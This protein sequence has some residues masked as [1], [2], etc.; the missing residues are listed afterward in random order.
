VNDLWGIGAVTPLVLVWIHVE[1]RAWGGV[2]S[3]LEYGIEAIS[4][5]ILKSALNCARVMI[6]ITWML[7]LR[8]IVHTIE[9][10]PFFQIMRILR[11]RTTSL[12]GIEVLLLNNWYCRSYDMVLVVL[13]VRCLVEWQTLIR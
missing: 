12:I 8:I 6:C 5:R 7:N 13:Q 1:K 11:I 9:W 4:S 2:L 3:I 10:A